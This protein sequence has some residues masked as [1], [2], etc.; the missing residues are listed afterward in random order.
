M[1]VL[2]LNIVDKNENKI[3]LFYEEFYCLINWLFC[4]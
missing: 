2:D 1:Y 4:G 3:L